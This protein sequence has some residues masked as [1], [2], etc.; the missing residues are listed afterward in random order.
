MRISRKLLSVA[1]STAMLVSQAMPVM[2]TAK[3]EATANIL[4]YTVETIVVPTTLKIALNPN[5]YEITT[6][7]QKA[8]TYAAGT[9]YYTASGEK[10][11]TQPGD[12]TEFAAGEFYTPVLATGQVVSLNYGIVNKSTEAKDVKV[13]FKASYTGAASGSSTKI[14]FVAT[15]AAA[16]PKS[17]S[18]ASG[19]EKNEYKV[20]LAVAS[21]TVAPTADTYKKTADTTVQSKTYYTKSGATYT[22]VASPSATDL[23]TYYEATTT[24]GTEIT[25][26]ELADV[27]MTKAT[28]GNQAFEKD[29]DD[30]KAKAE[31]GYRL[32]AAEYALKDGEKIDFSTTQAQL[33][34]KL[35]MK[36]IGGVIGFTL[37]GAVNKN[38][39][40]LKADAAAITIAPVY[41]L[42]DAAGEADAAADFEDNTHKQL[43]VLPTITDVAPS[44]ATKSY[45]VDGKAD[46]AITVDLGGGTLAATEISKIT[47]KST[48]GDTK[49]LDSGMYSLSGTTLTIKKDQVSAWIG[50]GQSSREYTIIFNDTAKTSVNVTMTKK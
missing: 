29:G 28:D 15:E 31:I 45:A 20:Y 19:A 27:N 26:A 34:D 49:N 1:L 10:A 32:A 22:K 9:T 13:S 24:I 4:D 30:N 46:V 8:T 3:T 48:T 50:A 41:Q 6:K 7:Y 40:W 47:F 42:V 2:A 14:E 33:K 44:I 37:T 43:K 21:A 12:A 38:A 17:D 39:D 5:E 35:T 18:N 23:T 36:E 11:S 16:Q 25:A